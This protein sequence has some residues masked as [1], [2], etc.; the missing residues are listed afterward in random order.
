MIF[1]CYSLVLEHVII[2]T[3][4]NERVRI[5][6]PLCVQYLCDLLN[7]SSAYALNE[8]LERMKQE[9]LKRACHVKMDEVE[10]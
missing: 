5:E 2:D 7:G 8:V 4:K 10:K 9:V 1:E 6:E 3:E